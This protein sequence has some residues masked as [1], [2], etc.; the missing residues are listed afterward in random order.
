MR[1]FAVL[2]CLGSA[3]LAG[4]QTSD[5][6]YLGMFLQGQRIGY[7]ETSVVTGSVGHNA[8]KRTNSRTLLDAGLL[9]A[10]MRTEII[11]STFTDANDKPVRMEFTIASAG[12][13]QRVDVAFL[14]STLEVLVDN[15]GVST[16]SSIPRPADAPI[17]DDAVASFML[18]SAPIGS[19]KHLYV[20]DPMTVTLVKNTVTHRGQA[21]LDTPEGKVKVEVVEVKEPRATMRAYLTAKGDLVKVDG[22][23]GIE[24]RPIS[25]EEA[26]G[27]APVRATAPDLAAI[28]AIRPD[29][30]I[31]NP[32]TIRRL[33]LKVQGA[34]LSLLPSDAFQTVRRAGD[35]WAVDVH[36]VTIDPSA[37]IATARAQFPQ[38]VKPS[39]N[40]S[41]DRKE[42]IQFAKASLGNAKTVADAAKL[43]RKAVFKLMRGNAGIGV[44]RDATE[45]LKTKEGVC[46]DYAV[47]TAAVLRASG[48]PTRLA[49]GLILMNGQ[50]YYH[51][52]V[53]V[54]DTRKWVGVDATL[55]TDGVA[56]DHL[57][58]AHGQ[59]EDA[60]TF[61]FL[62]KVKISVLDVRR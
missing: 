3:L 20:F 10:A 58:L 50:Y 48:V 19:S 39:M 7:V 23:M 54:W 4:A 47:L 43:A 22:P 51:A 5:A 55:P 18:G 14:P 52:W 1:W 60:F 31:E 30:P 11:A 57:K 17:V 6:S 40:V 34:D 21:E 33:S 59:V 62:D 46:R 56:A 37:K 27:A 26:L 38:W 61:T 15:N 2:T 32:A 24:M 25:R 9:G 44:L 49:S 35:A 41:S 28:T 36:P 53:E 16:K 13:T 29:R 45:V 42:V 8:V 12:R